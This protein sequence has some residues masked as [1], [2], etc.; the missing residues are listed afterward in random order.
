MY[1][2][3]GVAIAWTQDLLFWVPRR[4]ERLVGCPVSTYIYQI[5]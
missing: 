4:G 2:R 1:G 5:F 3:Y